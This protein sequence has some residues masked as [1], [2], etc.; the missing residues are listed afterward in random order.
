MN[1]VW[2]Y[3]NVSLRSG[4]FRKIN[5][6]K[7]LKH[8]EKLLRKQTSQEAL[9]MDPGNG[10][11][12]GSA[13]SKDKK[14]PHHHGLQPNHTRPL[15]VIRNYPQWVI[16]KESSVYLPDYSKCEDFSHLPQCWGDY[17]HQ[18]NKWLPYRADFAFSS[19]LILP[20]LIS[21]QPST[22]SMMI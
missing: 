9:G 3:S 19:S 1:H 6:T 21:V 12:P 13:K 14:T 7:K 15:W 2:Y 10:D 16:A 11:I 4:G 22:P 20:H 8:S 17:P 18:S 5:L